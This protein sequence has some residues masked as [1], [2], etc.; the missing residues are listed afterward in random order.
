M[1]CE[2]LCL[3][4][5]KTID[6]STFMKVNS[7]ICMTIVQIKAFFLLLKS[8]TQNKT[9]RVCCLCFRYLQKSTASIRVPTTYL[10]GSTKAPAESEDED[11]D[12]NWKVWV[13]IQVLALHNRL[14]LPMIK[15]KNIN[16]R[17]TFRQ[18]RGPLELY[19]PFAHH[20]RFLYLY[21]Q[22]FSWARSS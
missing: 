19:E 11:V 13:R 4:N 10:N 6:T 15:L 1:C 3:R 7:Q 8:L 16:C 18:Y 17:F 21:G 12:K 20:L 22:N 5:G 14:D 2:R 9:A